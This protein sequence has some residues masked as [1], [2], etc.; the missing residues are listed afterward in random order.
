MTCIS[1]VMSSG[2]LP[3]S[4][5]KGLSDMHLN[6]SELTRSMLFYGHVLGL[7]LAAYDE[8]RGVGYYWVGER[9]HALLGLWARP[10]SALFRQHIS[11][12]VALPDLQ[13]SIEALKEQGVALKNYFDERT[14]VPSVFGWM[15]AATIYFSD[16]D[17]HLLA[18]RARLSGAPRPELGVVS[19]PEWAGLSGQ[20]GASRG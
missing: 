14:D 11:F 20:E 12:E 5:F 15:P 9:G 16:P 3:G 4:L 13:R 1:S 2:A 17:G 18:F 7:E 6:V 8:A 10:G 19:L